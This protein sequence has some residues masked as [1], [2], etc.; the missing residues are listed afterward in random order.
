MFEC[1]TIDQLMRERR[2]DGSG[3]LKL[4]IEG[5]EHALLSRNFSSASPQVEQQCR[6]TRCERTC[7]KVSA[8]PIGPRDDTVVIGRRASRAARQPDALFLHGEDV[9]CRPRPGGSRRDELASV[10]GREPH[11]RR[12]TRRHRRWSA[13]TYGGKVDP[14]VL[15]KKSATI[16]AR[17]S[18]GSQY[19]GIRSTRAR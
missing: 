9:A 14:R 18:T 11:S 16:P 17:P 19:T 3:I 2:A 10:I 13:T 15:R 12:L 4:D 1:T 8:R 7:S 6:I 5:G